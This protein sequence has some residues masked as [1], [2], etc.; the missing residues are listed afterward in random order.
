MTLKTLT[1]VG[2][3]SVCPERALIVVLVAHTALSE[4]M[5]GEGFHHKHKHMFEYENEQPLLLPVIEVLLEEQ[6]VR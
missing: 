2:V 4:S 6:V 3:S 5:V 1:V